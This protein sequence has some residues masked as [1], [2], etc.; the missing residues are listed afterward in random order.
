MPTPNPNYTGGGNSSGYNNTNSG[1]LF[2]NDRKEKDN[3]PDHRGEVEVKCPHCGKNSN[4]WLAA[5]IKT[6]RTSGKKFFS[7]A[8]T[9][10]EQTPA[11]QGDNMGGVVDEDIPI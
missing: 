2:R 3:Q 5:W 9:E 7:L 1:A 10:K 4:F 8:L 6:A 11:P